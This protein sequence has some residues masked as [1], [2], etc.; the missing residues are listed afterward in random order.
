MNASVN[1]EPTIQEIVDEAV[2]AAVFATSKYLE[3]NPNNW[4]PCG[5]AWVKIKPAR[6]KLVTYLKDT[7]LGNVSMMGGLDVWNP[8]GNSTQ[9]MYAKI[10]G[11][12]AFAAVL[13]KYG[14]SA[15]VE[16][17]ID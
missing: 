14:Y 4:Y 16:S 2:I 13:K 17:R 15:M 8:S 7:G 3:A 10:E 9:S 11:A 12:K 6:G 5:F 1:K